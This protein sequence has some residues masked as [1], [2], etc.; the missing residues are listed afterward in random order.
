MTVEEE[1][2][3]INQSLSTLRRVFTSLASRQGVAP[4]REC[5]LTRI[6]QESLQIESKTVII[7]NVCS[8]FNSIRQTKETLEFAS[9]SMTMPT[10][11]KK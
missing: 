2:T 1:G 7:I 5:K 3:F 10:A 8:E 11:S 6:L 4:Y 9:Q